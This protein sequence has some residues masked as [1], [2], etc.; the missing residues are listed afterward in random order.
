MNPDTN[1]ID[2]LTCQELVELVTAYLEGVMNPPD[3]AR[4]EAHLGG[5][6]GCRNYV[7]QM[8]QTVRL[9]GTIPPETLDDEIQNQLLDAFRAWKRESANPPL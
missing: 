7:T 6:T 8:R 2:I 5:C 9:L 1:T 3:Q 4:F